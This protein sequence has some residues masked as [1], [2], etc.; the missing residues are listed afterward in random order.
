MIK[1]YLQFIFEEQDHYLSLKDMANVFEHFPIYFK[2][3]NLVN[4]HC[5]DFLRQNYLQYPELDLLL[6]LHDQFLYQFICIYNII[7]IL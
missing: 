5:F 7:Q 3:A 4:G 6:H 2:S 1:G